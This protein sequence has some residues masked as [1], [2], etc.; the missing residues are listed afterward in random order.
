MKKMVNVSAER[1]DELVWNEQ[2]LFQLIH[3]G[4]NKLEIYERAQKIVSDR[5]LESES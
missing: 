2:L 5:K 3:A 4:V 1:I